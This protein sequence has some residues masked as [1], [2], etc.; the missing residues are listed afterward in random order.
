MASGEVRLRTGVLRS[1]EGCMTI[2]KVPEMRPGELVEL[3]WKRIAEANEIEEG[4]DPAPENLH[5]GGSAERPALGG[6]GDS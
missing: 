4:N 6:G 2:P 1:E 5:A 3:W